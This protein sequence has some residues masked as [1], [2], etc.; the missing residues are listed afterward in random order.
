MG[1]LKIFAEPIMVND[2]VV[3]AISFGYGNPPS[4][5][6]TLQDL[7]YKYCVDIE[8]LKI[9]SQK[10]NPRPDFIIKIAKKR[11]KSIA[12]LIGEIIFR[13]QIEI[14]FQ[15]KNN[16]LIIAKQKVEENERNFKSYFNS[17][18]TATFIW[19]FYNDDLILIE[20]NET[21]N[22]ITDDKAKNF[23]GLSSKQ[24][25]ADLPF[26]KDKLF[27]CYSEKSSIEFEHK[28]LARYSHSYEWIKFKLT[29]LKPDTVILYAESITKQK[30]DELDLIKSKESAEENEEKYRLLINN[31]NDLVCEINENG[32]YT[33]VSSRYEDILGYDPRELTG[34]SAVDLIHPDDLAESINKY[35]Q[36]IEKPTNS[37]DIWRFKH[38]NGNYRIIESKGK[39]FHNTKNEKRT[40]VISR[41][42]TD[43][44]NAENELKISITQLI[45]AQK[46]GKIGSFEYFISENK[47]NWSDEMY[48]VFG[49][50]NNGTPLSYEQ[51][52]DMIHPDDRQLHYEQTQQIIKQ[53]YYSF[54]HR[55][56]LSDGNIRWISGNAK[57]EYSKNGE[58]YRMLGTVQDITR[59][60]K[61]EDDLIKAKEKAEESDRLKTAFLQNMSHEIRTPMNAIMGFSS[62]LPEAYNNKE[63]LIQYSNIIQQRCNYLLDII[64]D[65][66]DISKIES[67]Q[68]G[69]TIDDCNLNELFIELDSFFLDY[70][71]RLQK[72]N[73]ELK[74]HPIG[75]QSKNIILTDK[76]KLKQIL[77][78]L[79]SNAVKFTD[80]GTI[81]CSCKYE[82]NKVVFKVSDT[83]I[84]I[85]KE[86][87]DF[88]FQRFTQLKHHSSFN[89]GGA[90]LGLSIVK[91]LTIQLGGNV[92][93]ESDYGKGTTFYFS[94][95]HIPGGDV[96]KNDV[97]EENNIKTKIRDNT[98]LIVEDDEYNL[99][100]LKEVLKNHFT[101]I[102]SAITGKDAIQF[103]QN[104]P[105]D[106][107]LMDVRLPDMSGYEASNEIIKY[108]PNIKIIAQTAYA[109]QEEYQKA[110]KNGC[111]D[112]I[113]KPTKKEQ[114]LS[115]LSKLL[116]EFNK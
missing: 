53:G 18:P 42:I 31:I 70:K 89:V 78:N 49:C 86:K 39:V 17:N 64:S 94:I 93:L 38:K 103:V 91:A 99:L 88:I 108:D 72:Q 29:Y 5:F 14:S 113:S 96:V 4:D 69:V 52:I 34:R 85:P 9:N 33:F 83:G 62:L 19:K 20:V 56:L 46:I 7:S 27:E 6:K 65:I 8:L 51:V 73:I 101:N 13:K 92:W 44:K 3:G 54:E 102:F 35:R 48:N 76:S 115:V 71:R 24:I 112:Y 57:M 10:Y 2:D 114:L 104:N 47:V 37:V 59:Q 66:L 87:F 105:V 12:K 100:Y 68:S 67:G 79:I 36:L 28:Y 25:Y 43:Q 11:L 74:L 21:A 16:E 61:L 84:G 15:Q 107:I 95:D 22:R 60:K 55:I 50:V 98:I 110:L 81:V 82:N 30:Q 40:V 75:D 77:I 90:G 58:P 1:G 45:Q 109:S 41:D 97:N 80:T 32:I 116:R 63:D 26:I 106:I 111:V 23:I